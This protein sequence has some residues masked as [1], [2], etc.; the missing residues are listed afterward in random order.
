MQLLY[1]IH[2]EGGNLELTSLTFRHCGSGLQR[3]RR[4]TR[5]VEM[6]LC[7]DA[8]ATQVA[9]LVAMEQIGCPY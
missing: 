5:V 6:A 7:W 4:T 3:K 9:I 2:I 8:E 1:Q